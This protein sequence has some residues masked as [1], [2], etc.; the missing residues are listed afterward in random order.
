[1]ALPVP[2]TPYTSL[3]PATDDRAVSARTTNPPQ[4]GL[5]H[6]GVVSSQGRGHSIL[7]LT[8][9]GRATGTCLTALRTLPTS[10]GFAYRSSESHCLPVVAV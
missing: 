9:A 3:Y 10:E 2:D 7:P 6:P 8:G 1:M 5:N 4:S